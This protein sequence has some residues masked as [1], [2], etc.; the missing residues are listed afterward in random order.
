MIHGSLKVVYAHLHTCICTHV[1][2][3]HQLIS[4]GVEDVDWT[5]ANFPD[6]VA[7]TKA[8]VC[9]E[10]QSTL[11]TIRQH[12]EV[13]RSIADTWSKVPGMDLFSTEKGETKLT[14]L[15]GKHRWVESEF[16]HSSWL[17]IYFHTCTCTYSHTNV[18]MHNCVTCHT[19]R[20]LSWNFGKT[21]CVP[22]RYSVS[23]SKSIIS[24]AK[25]KLYTG[26]RLLLILTTISI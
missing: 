18:I 20:V 22:S 9:G 10:L 26:L 21:D 3:H 7:K 16:C 11:L 25:A 23:I 13:I 1:Y 14:V 8:A 15:E 4:V 6:F 2:I 17:F 12:A 5:S 24:L 19:K